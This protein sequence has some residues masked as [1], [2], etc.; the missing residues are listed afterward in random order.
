[1]QNWYLRT[2]VFFNALLLDDNLFDAI[3]NLNC[4]SRIKLSPNVGYGYYAFIYPLAPGHHTIRWTA[5][6]ALPFL[7]TPHQDVT[8]H[9]T[10][11]PK[12]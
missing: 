12:R 6:A 10:V 11:R 2:K 9:V 1:M 4:Y 3:A 7:G 5:D 8:Y